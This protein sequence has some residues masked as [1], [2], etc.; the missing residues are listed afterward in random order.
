MAPAYWMRS[1]RD[2]L[3]YPESHTIYHDKDGEG[4]LDYAVQ[5]KYY[6]VVNPQYNNVV[7]ERHQRLKQAKCK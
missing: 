1:G 6:F 2:I 5:D 4:A 7:V 3:G